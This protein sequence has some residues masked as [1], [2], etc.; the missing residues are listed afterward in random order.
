MTD[1]TSVKFCHL[2]DKF[3][4]INGKITIASRLTDQGVKYGVAYCSPKDRFKKSLGRTIAENRLNDSD[5]VINLTQEEINH[6]QI[7]ISILCDINDHH[8]FPEWAYEM[9]LDHI[10]WYCTEQDTVNVNNSDINDVDSV[11]TW[12]NGIPKVDSG[13]L[14]VMITQYF[15]EAL[16]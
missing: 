9:I 13:L 12:L 6:K 2:G 15:D 3:T 7:M 4:N 1:T 5:H 16:K 11:M 8:D 14:K 10:D